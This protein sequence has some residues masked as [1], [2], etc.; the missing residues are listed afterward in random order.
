V[1]LAK[2]R[3]LNLLLTGFEVATQLPAEVESLKT[4]LSSLKS[5]RDSQARTAELQNLKSGVAGILRAI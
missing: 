1:F 4:S 5:A 3:N 2:Y